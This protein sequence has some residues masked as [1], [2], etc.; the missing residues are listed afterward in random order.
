L[1]AT[2]VFAL[3][4]R[5][6][7]S[8]SA[9]EISALPGCTDVE[10]GYRRISAECTS[11]SDLL[12]LRTVDDLFLHLAEWYD[13]RHT[14]RALQDMAQQSAHL[15]LEQAASIC[16][17]VR[18][19]KRRPTFSISASFVGKR[20]YSAPEI[21]QVCAA[22]IAAAH[23][24]RYLDDEREADLNVRIFIEHARAWVG[25]RLAQR[26][27][28]E[29]PYKHVNLPGSLKPPVAAALLVLAG[30][31]PGLRVLD[32]TCGAG[33]I[34]IE[35]ALS[36]AQVLGGDLNTHALHA[37]QINAKAANVTLDLYKWDA[38]QLPIAD[39]SI[40]RMVTNLPWGRQISVDEPLRA[41]YERVCSEIV[42]VLRVGGR[43][44]LLTS[45][46]ELLRLDTLHLDIGFEISLYGQT[47]TVL[48]F[49]RH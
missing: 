46:S 10:I 36:G 28:H 24:W 17:E 18:P 1:A 19:L 49:S 26:P 41:F 31:Q 32:P 45:T 2:R 12:R 33:T 34:V 13:I 22:S 7:E 27:L 35:A 4:T 43:V 29:R 40:D 37:A 3:T 11:V 6:L 23:D 48:V 47:P 39:G 16:N 25:V 42:R 15:P 5:G 38:Q 21:K 14:R 8:V 20:N 30:V 9:A 44:G